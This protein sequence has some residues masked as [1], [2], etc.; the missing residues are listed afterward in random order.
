MIGARVSKTGSDVETVKD[1][2]TVMES[3]F[4][5]PR[6]IHEGYF[7]VPAAELDKD[8]RPI[9]E[10]ICKH[11]LG[12]YPMF[13]VFS[14]DR[15]DT[16]VGKSTLFYT[17]NLRM[18]KNSLNWYENNMSLS[19]YY[20]IFDFD[21]DRPQKREII[22]TGEPEFYDNKFTQQ[23]YGIKVSKRGTNITSKSPQDILFSSD[24]YHPTVHMVGHDKY[25]IAPKEVFI[26]HGLGYAPQFWLYI[27][28]LN[29]DNNYQMVL[30]SADDF[31]YYTNSEEA[32]F[33]TLYNNIEY[34]F[35]IMKEPL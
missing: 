22:K 25:N 15:M 12:Y 1:F 28:N 33:A 14:K 26:K 17:A 8:F 30:S 19:G 16:R 20:F 7:S 5:S 9:P 11:E 6:I 3:S 13:M 21:L 23:K 18:S 27:K 35:I 4:M 31:L 32:V 24:Y 10:V 34:S 29:E 2:D